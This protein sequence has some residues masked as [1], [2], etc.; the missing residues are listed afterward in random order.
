MESVGSFELTPIRHGRSLECPSP[1]FIAQIAG[2][3]A[4]SAWGDGVAVGVGPVV[5]FF[6][7]YVEIPF[8][9]GCTGSSHSD[10]HDQ[11]WFGSF[12]HVCHLIFKRNL[13]TSGNPLN[14][15]LCQV[16]MAH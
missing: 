5:V 13:Y 6:A 1:G 12:H 9:C 3:D 7:I 4:V 16:R 14:T 8:G 2:D 11:Q 10:G 15:N